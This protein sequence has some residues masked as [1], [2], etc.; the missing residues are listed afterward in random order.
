MDNDIIHKTEIFN[1]RF[2]VLA[3]FM[4]IASFFVIY[5]AWDEIA[6]SDNAF[7]LAFSA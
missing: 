6:Y 7:L 4:F 3:F 5:I 1:F 2:G